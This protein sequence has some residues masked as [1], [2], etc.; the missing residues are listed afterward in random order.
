MNGGCSRAPDAGSPAGASCFPQKMCS[1]MLNCCLALQHLVVQ[2]SSMCIFYLL[3]LPTLPEETTHAQATIEL[4]ARSLF[5]C[6]ISTVL[7][8]TLG[9][10]LPLVQIPSFEYLVPAMVLSSHLSLSASMDRNGTAV[11]SACPAPHCPVAGSQ[12]ASLQEVSGAVLV[13]GLVQLVLGVSGVCGWAVQRCGPMVLAPSL[14]IIGL[15]AYREAAF[16]CS[17][18]WGVA[19]LFMLLAVTFSQHLGSCRLPFCAWSQARGGS[20]ETSLPT[21]RTFSILFPFAVVCIIC[22]ILRH[23]HV[24]WESL[25]LAT[26]QLSW[27]NSTFHAPWLRIPYAGKRGWPLLTPRALAVGI[28]MAIGCSINSVS[29]YVLWGRLLGT[30]ASVANTCA[31][32]F[33]QAGSRFPVQVSALACVMLGM[34]PRLAGLLTCIPL[35]VHGGVLCITYAVAVGTGISYF[36]YADIDSGRNI[37]IVGF[38]MFMALLVPRWLSM[39]PAHLATGWVPLDLLFLSLLTMPVFLTGFLSFFLEN[40]VSGTLEE[41]GLLSDLELRK[42]GTGS[43]HPRG[44]RREASHVYGL[45]TALR[46]LLPTSCKAF[47]CCFLC[48]ESEEEEEEEED[49]EEEGSCT[50]E[51]G[52]AAPGEGTHLL[53]KPGSGEQQWA[54]RPSE[55]EMPAWHPVA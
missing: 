10:R 34:S 6:G 1:W 50:N 17:T 52:T 19:L 37:F 31:T 47:P 22:A 9:S 5:A 13:S 43:H 27:A 30:A 36:Q 49:E 29:C 8:T 26:T 48:P 7:Q 28:A 45:P 18:N 38:T 16:F 54:R 55:T 53:P 32:G 51:E 39:A 41:R 12:A 46:R 20:M 33:T 14:S 44:E 24:P 21:L 11:A 25:D 23:L 42:A 15:S 3:L 35:V 2:A 40:T 4:L